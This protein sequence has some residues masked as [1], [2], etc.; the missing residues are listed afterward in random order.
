MIS[1][2]PSLQKA[3]TFVGFFRGHEC[4]THD[5]QHL[6]LK[7]MNICI[8]GLYHK[9]LFL[10]IIWSR[11]WFVSFSYWKRRTAQILLGTY[12]VNLHAV[13]RYIEISLYYYK[14]ISILHMYEFNILLLFHKYTY[15]SIV[16]YIL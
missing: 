6:H 4:S 16:I 14:I 8:A 11:M 10:S 7:H 1:P 3:K 2:F 9:K 5:P 12:T 13:G 15:V